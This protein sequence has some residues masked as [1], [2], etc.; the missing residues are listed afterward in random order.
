MQQITSKTSN[1][2]LKLFARVA[3]PSH[4]TPVSPSR[5]LILVRTPRIGLHSPSQRSCNPLWRPLTLL[6]REPAREM[7]KELVRSKLPCLS[8]ARVF[9]WRRTRRLPRATPS[10]TRHQQRV[11]LRHLPRLPLRLLPRFLPRLPLRLLPRLP[12]S[13]TN[14][15]KCPRL[16][17]WPGAIAGK[18]RFA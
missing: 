6:Q 10:R 3:L 14:N 4:M 11:P 7:A 2:A 8:T 1:P 12:P 17:Q 16:G 9:L 5:I 18:R 15:H 13:I